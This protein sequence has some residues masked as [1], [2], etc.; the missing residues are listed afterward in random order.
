[1]AL[2]YL[3]QL[4][5]WPID[6]PDNGPREASVRALFPDIQSAVKGTLLAIVVIIS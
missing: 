4:A 2:L 1:M 3:Y 6:G 5:T